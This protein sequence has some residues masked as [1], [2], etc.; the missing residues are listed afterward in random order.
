LTFSP[1][2]PPVDVVICR[3]DSAGKCLD[4][5]DQRAM[6]SVRE[7]NNIKAAV[8]ELNHDNGLKIFQG[9]LRIIKMWAYRRQI[10]GSSAGYLGGGGWAVLLLWVWQQDS[11][12]LT[13]MFQGQDNTACSLVLT[14][15]FFE[16]VGLLWENNPIIALSGA[17]FI[18]SMDD[19]RTTTMNILSIRSGNLGISSTISTTQTT[20]NEI[21]RA[22]SLF[23]GM[24][25][26]GTVSWPTSLQEALIGPV[27]R[28]N[29]KKT[30]TLCISMNRKLVGQSIKPADIKAWSGVG[31]LRLTVALERIVSSH[32]IRPYSRPAV[33]RDGDN[34]C[35]WFFLGLSEETT[36][37]DSTLTE[38]CD[39][40]T[41]RLQEEANVS[42]GGLN[43]EDGAAIKATVKV[44]SSK[45][46]AIV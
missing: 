6:D 24:K 44:Y 42:F 4:A 19:I 34:T 45:Q 31:A 39:T 14:R 10:Y 36:G 16:R 37:Q 33:M 30:L 13:S 1:S 12:V 5:A 21:S 40:Y 26:T 38:F 35:F 32:S 8:S 28:G 41:T 43:G 17:E 2:Y 20:K 27:H 25:K 46:I 29:E 23:N 7:T 11:Q 3:V 9:A 22:K 15:L 18:P